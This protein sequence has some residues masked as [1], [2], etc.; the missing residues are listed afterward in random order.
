MILW[1]H[2]LPQYLLQASYGESAGNMMLR[3]G[4]DAGP[5]KVRRRFTAAPRD[6]QGEIIVTQDQFAFF[7]TWYNNVLLGGTLRFGWTEPW[8]DT[9]LTNILSNGGFDNT[10]TGWSENPDEDTTATIVSGGVFGNCAQI[11]LA[12]G[13]YA[14]I[15]QTIS[16]S[17][18]NEYSMS[19]YVKS[20]TS[21]DVTFI[22]NLNEAGVANVEQISGTSTDDW[23]YYHLSFTLSATTNQIH[24]YESTTVD[25]TIFFDEMSIVDIT[26][27]IVEMRFKEPP[28]Y[29]SAGGTYIKISM[30]LEI[31]P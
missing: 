10:L 7:K 25:G 11:E 1:P 24:I 13:S 22:F 20:G 12:S 8:S 5:D 17:I 2:I 18:G 28:T 9:V 15:E 19:G 23:T 31:L 16:L 14:G 6:L 26:T 3:S 4:M 27:G 30:N 21:G 29:S